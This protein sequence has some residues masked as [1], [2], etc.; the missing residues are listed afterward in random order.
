MFDAGELHP[1][2]DLLMDGAD[3]D[4]REAKIR[5]T[6]NPVARGEMRLAFRGLVTEDS[7]YFC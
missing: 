5:I 1:L 2:L 7:R 6:L 4:K 3:I